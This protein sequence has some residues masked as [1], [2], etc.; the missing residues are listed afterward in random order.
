MYLLFVFAH[1]DDESFYS[2]GTIAKL[3][4]ERHVVKLITAT[5]G[6]A[7]QLGNPPL[8]A[9]KELGSVREK[10]LRNAAK[11]LG[12]S[13]IFFLGFTD[14][15]LESVPIKTLSEKILKIFNTERP[16]VVITFNKEGGSRHPDHRRMNKVATEAFLSYMKNVKKHVRLYYADIPRSHVKK[17]EALS[18]VY[19]YFGKIKGTPDK[20]ITT[21]VDVSDTINKKI[22]AFMSH[23][24]QK[25]D[26]EGFLKRKN[27]PEFTKEFFSLALENEIA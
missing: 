26:W 13:E 10:E 1:P 21:T 7:G 20:K 2:G 3:V 24:T 18:M 25:K 4:K 11:I 17:M 6:E 27:H 19:T 23:V 15:K 12:I 22:K 5:K 16:D 14:G 9:K 8:C